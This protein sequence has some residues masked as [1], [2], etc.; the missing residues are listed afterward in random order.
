MID[1]YLSMILIII[2]FIIVIYSVYNVAYLEGVKY[3]V[4]KQYNQIYNKGIIDGTILTIK[5]LHSLGVID[6]P[7]TKELIS[8]NIEGITLEEKK[9]IEDLIKLSDK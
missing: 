2:S 7:K 9:F 3:A 6:V 4:K 1:P 8:K 5:D